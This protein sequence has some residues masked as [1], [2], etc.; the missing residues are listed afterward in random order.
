M[1]DVKEMAITFTPNLLAKFSACNE[2]EVLYKL[3]NRYILQK[4]PIHQFLHCQQLQFIACHLPPPLSQLPQVRTNKLLLY[5]YTLFYNYT[6]KNTA[7]EFVTV[8]KYIMV[9]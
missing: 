9:E 3:L 6:S 5:F 1:A 2:I 8:K 7:Y 4:L